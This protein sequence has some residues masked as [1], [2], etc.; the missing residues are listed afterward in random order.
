M[1]SCGVVVAPQ[2]GRFR[3]QMQSF[4]RAENKSAGS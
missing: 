2:I 3:P 1:G 4:R